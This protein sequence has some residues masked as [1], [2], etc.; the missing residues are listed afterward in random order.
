MVDE[1]TSE[2]DPFAFLPGQYVR[3]CAVVNAPGEGQTDDCKLS[4]SGVAGCVGAEH[5]GAYPTT[6]HVLAYL[7]RNDNPRIFR[8]RVPEGVLRLPAAHKV[9]GGLPREPELSRG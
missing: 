2:N 5:L 8:P 7:V 4:V 1:V 9:A 6:F 3:A